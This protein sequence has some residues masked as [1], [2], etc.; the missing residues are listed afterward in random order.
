MGDLTQGSKLAE[1]RLCDQLYTLRI[2][3][4][5]KLILTT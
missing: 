3:L 4:R 1:T 2:T 5:D